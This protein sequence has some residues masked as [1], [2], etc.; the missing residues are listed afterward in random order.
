MKTPPTLDN[1]KPTDGVSMGCFTH[2]VN[3]PLTAVELIR[4]S[5]RGNRE[6]AAHWRC[7]AS[8]AHAKHDVRLLVFAQEMAV[9]FD[10]WA[11]DDEASLSSA[12]SSVAE[13]VS[14]GNV[15]VVA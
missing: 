14:Y 6:R 4:L 10:G 2:Q 3:T 9:M 13:L 11:L 15:G 5:L 7:Q 8:V 1:T 12:L